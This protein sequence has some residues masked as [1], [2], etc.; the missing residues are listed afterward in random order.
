MTLIPH[1]L[2]SGLFIRA[3]LNAVAD[4]LVTW[5]NEEVV[6][7]ATRA[8]KN[9][10][11]LEQA[12]KHVEER[13][14]D[15]D[16]GVLVAMGQWTGFFDNHQYQWMAG[17]EMYVLCMRL[18]T[19][20]CY[21]CHQLSEHPRACDS[22]QFTHHRFVGGESPVL[23]R[24]IQLHKDGSWK[25]DAVGTPLPFENLSAYEQRT[26]KD[27]LSAEML[28]NYGEALGIRFWDAQSYQE[29][30]VLLRWGDGRDDSPKTN[31]SALK[32]IMGILGR[33]SL[34]MDRWGRRRGS[35]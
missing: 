14:F 16:R 23:V 34:I 35:E 12:W 25:F 11:S 6:N 10:R 26:K 19:D 13:K 27:R 15:P 3:P 2:H 8:E 28:R 33:P 30:I 22:A 20:T 32:K 24:Q 29:E 21:F 9:H 7:R 5:G 17:A 1:G 31:E 18:K 4:C